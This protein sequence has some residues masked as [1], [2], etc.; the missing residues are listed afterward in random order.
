ML[1][2]QIRLPVA[3]SSFVHIPGNT[4]LPA[5]ECHDDLVFD[6][7]RRGCEAVAFHRV[8]HLHFPKRQA[9][10]GVESDQRGVERAE[11]HSIPQYRDAAIERIYFVGIDA[12]LRALITPDLQSCLGVER[13]RRS[14]DPVVYMIPSI[15]IG[16]ASRLDFPGN[17]ITQRDCRRLAFRRV[18]LVER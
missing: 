10:S 4:E 11:K 6:R 15:T 17:C 2:R 8:V 9:G 1:N 5:G 3:G 14:G 16:V 13:D 18:D 7:E 12:L